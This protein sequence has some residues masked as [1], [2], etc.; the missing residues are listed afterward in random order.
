MLLRLG[1]ASV[2][3]RER[4]KAQST[5]LPDGEGGIRLYQVKSQH[6]LV[7]AGANL[8]RFRDVIGFADTDKAA[9]LDGLLAKYRRNCQF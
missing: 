2:L 9:K 3:Y 7:V 1:I 6:E 8:E 4:R 5:L